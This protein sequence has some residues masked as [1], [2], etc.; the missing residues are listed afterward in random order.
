MSHQNKPRQS[1][2][3]PVFWNDDMEHLRKLGDA[4]NQ[5]LSGQTNNQFTVDI[6][7][8]T[9]ETVVMYEKCRP[10]ISVNL[11]PASVGA[12]TMNV[13]VEPKIGSATIHHDSDPSTDRKFFVVFVG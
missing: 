11:T 13:W 3:V 12:S 9:T 10:D 2:K 4:T 1:V 8:D 5:A 7:P 6:D